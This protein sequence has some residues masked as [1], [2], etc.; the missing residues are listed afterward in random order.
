[1]QVYGELLGVLD[2]PV[3]E[4][5]VFEGC[6]E[7]LLACFDEAGGA[8]VAEVLEYKAAAAPSDAGPAQA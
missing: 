3:M 6:A 5:L 7:D 2:S 1:M 4:L 8:D